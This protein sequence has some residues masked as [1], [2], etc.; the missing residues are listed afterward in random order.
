MLA[1]P[2][3]PSVGRRAISQWG[4]VSSQIAD[5]PTLGEDHDPSLHLM[6]A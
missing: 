3:V 6:L 1:L 2:S 4:G 5:D